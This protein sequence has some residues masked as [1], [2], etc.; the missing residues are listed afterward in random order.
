MRCKLHVVIIVVYCCF[1][2]LFTLFTF[3]KIAAAIL[4]VSLLFC[5]W[6]HFC[7]F[8]EVILDCFLWKQKRIK[9]NNYEINKFIVRILS[10][11]I[12]FHTMLAFGLLIFLNTAFKL[13][14]M[15]SSISIYIYIFSTIWSCKLTLK[16]HF[17]NSSRL[18]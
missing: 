7:N 11:S 15:Q 2:L 16:L 3:I 5:K 13:F 14:P 18:Q 1:F 6:E 4:W 17:N 9:T 8:Y 12:F 10:Q